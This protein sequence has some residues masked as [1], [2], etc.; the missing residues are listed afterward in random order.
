VITGAASGIGSALASTLAGRGCHL[1]LVDRNAAGLAAVAGRLRTLG[2]KVSEHAFD[3]TDVSAIAALPEAVLATHG[4]VTILV[5]NAG[6]AMGGL[7]EDVTPE[8]FALVFEVNFWS[9]VRLMRAFLPVLRREQAAQIVNISS[10]FGLVAPAGQ[11]PYCATKFAVRAVSEAVRHEL[12]EENGPVRLSVVHPGGVR[13]QILENAR[14]PD[15]ATEEEAARERARYAKLLAAP[16]EE[17]AEQI[18]RGIERR[19]KRILVGSYVRQGDL[20]QRFWPSQYWFFLRLWM[21]A[22]VG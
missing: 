2:I 7:F 9:V 13:T 15:T 21:K 3:L 18:V 8:D 17:V 12:Q 10:L 19:K 1:A 6:I 16:P 20:L 5:N 22:K 4:R 11:S 14:K